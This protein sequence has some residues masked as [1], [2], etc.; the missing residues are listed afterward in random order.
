ML[1]MILPVLIQR[2]VIGFKAILEKPFQHSYHDKMLKIYIIITKKYTYMKI[3]TKMPI[4]Q[5]LQIHF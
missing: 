5:W 1:Y 4:M 2:I 3:E